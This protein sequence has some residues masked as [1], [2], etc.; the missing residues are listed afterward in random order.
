ML[1]RLIRELILNVIIKSS[2]FTSKMSVY[3][4]FREG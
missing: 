2:Q 3:S 1:C 4:P